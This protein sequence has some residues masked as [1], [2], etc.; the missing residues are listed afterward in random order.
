MTNFLPKS[1]RALIEEFS[2]LPGIGPKSAQ[3]LAMHLLHSPEN[4]VKDLGDAVIGLK[5]NVTFCETCWNI[6]E[7]NPC[8]ICSDSSR[9]KSIIC[10]VEEVL[11][12]NAI[13]KTGQYNGLYHVLHGV[14]SPIDGIGPDQLKI[15]SL[16]D[17]LKEGNVSEIILATNPSLEGET[18]ALYIQKQ[19][20]GFDL[21]IT[22]IA[23]GLPIGGDL[24]YADEVTLSK[25][26][27]GRIEF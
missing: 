20:K 17:R 24:E 2:K 9:N 13:E 16:I 5:T 1:I 25:A 18:T 6:A 15:D 26:M 19:L 14:L 10:V 4:R 22:R 21:K 23:R 8:K 3:R 12:A 11:D 27:N 7:E